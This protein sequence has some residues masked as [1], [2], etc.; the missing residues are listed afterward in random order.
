MNRSI[1]IKNL[2]ITFLKNDILEI[3]NDNIGHSSFYSK[4]EAK[5]L[6]CVLGMFLEEQS[7]SATDQS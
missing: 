4:E 6:Y 3:H 2:T 1:T 5:G 7:Q